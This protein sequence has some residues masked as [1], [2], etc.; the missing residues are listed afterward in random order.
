MASSKDSMTRKTELNP[1]KPFMGKRT[2]LQ[3]FIQETFVFLTINKEH[4]NTNDKK[5]A[6]VVLFMNNEDTSIWKQEF[7]SRIMKDTE[8]MTTLSEHTRHLWIALRSCSCLT[9][10][11][12][13]HSKR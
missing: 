3:C 5:I 7:I 10:D 6:F 13:M 9:M 8:E 11:Q 12:V 4:Y 1:L 2:D